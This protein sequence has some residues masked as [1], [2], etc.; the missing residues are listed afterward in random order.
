MKK[1]N[2]RKI[3]VETIAKVTAVAIM[4]VLV[5][6]IAVVIH[7]WDKIFPT[8]GQPLSS[9]ADKSSDVFELQGDTA[10]NVSDAEASARVIQT[11]N[12]EAVNV[13]EPEG[14]EQGEETAEA[15]DTFSEE[16][17]YNENVAQII[18]SA[19]TD[20]LGTPYRSGGASPEKGFDSTG[21]TY[22]CVNQ[23]G[24]KF[25]RNLKDQ[26]ESGLR[27]PYEELQAGDIVYFSAEAGGEATFCGVYV[28][29]GLIIYSP[30][31]DDFVKTANITTNYWTTHF[32]T[33]LRVTPQ[34][35]E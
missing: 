3:M 28:G 9:T 14:D 26:L 35:N 31:P 32:V 24:I 22:Y 6:G 23:A 5:A 8:Q 16:S 29:G 30:V 13:S 33:G 4:L 15:Q 10:T 1:R 34:T 27:I 7:S 25:P 2:S 20:Q 11:G 12:S 18:V 21:F 17:A 19:A